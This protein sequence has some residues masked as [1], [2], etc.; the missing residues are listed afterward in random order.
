MLL[1]RIV[2]ARPRLFFCAALGALTFFVIPESVA[3]RVTT[4]LILSWNVGAWLYLALAVHMMF[5]SDRD[6][7]RS[8]AVRQDDGRIAILVLV[9]LAAVATIGAIAAEL[10]VAK[11]LAGTARY[12][13]VALAGLTL[14]SSWFFTHVMFALHY[15]HDYILPA[16]RGEPGGLEFAGPEEPDYIDFLY[17]SCI[18]GTSGQTADVNISTSAMRRTALVHCVLA[19]FYNATLIALTINIASGFF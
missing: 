10:G 15:A 14:V 6:K 2:R 17:F 8:R 1:I 5:S 4:R 7:L 12:E 16:S 9:I 13:H 18:I 11:E 3:N 19:F